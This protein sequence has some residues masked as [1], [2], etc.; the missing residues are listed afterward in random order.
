MAQPQYGS[1][2]GPNPPQQ[3][4][5]QIDVIAGEAGHT[6]DL[7]PAA[8]TGGTGGSGLGGQAETAPEGGVM[9]D[10]IGF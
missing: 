2:V 10:R 6:R 5:T 7:P 8:F 4:M 1:E 9:Y 3:D